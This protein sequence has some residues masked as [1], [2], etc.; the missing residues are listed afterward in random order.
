[1]SKKIIGIIILSLVI[2]NI[3]PILNDI[4]PETVTY[5]FL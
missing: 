3:I 5:T 2:Y 4:F 1:M